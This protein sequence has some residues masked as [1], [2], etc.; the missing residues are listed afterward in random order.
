MISAPNRGELL[1]MQSALTT[2]TG[3]PIAIPDSYKNHKVIIK[4][5]AGISAGAVQIETAD[6][7]DYAGTWAQVGGG[8]ITAVASTELAIDFSGVYKFIRTRITTNIVGGTVTTSY[9]G[10]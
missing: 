4:G 9:V 3:T 8:P 1:V 2:G 5:S 7:Y 10:S 6:A